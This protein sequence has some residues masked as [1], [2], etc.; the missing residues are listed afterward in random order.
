M[1][2]SNAYLRRH[3][4]LF[5]KSGLGSIDVCGWYSRFNRSHLRC[6]WSRVWLIFKRHVNLFIF[7]HNQSFLLKG[8]ILDRHAQSHSAFYLD[9]FILLRCNL[10]KIVSW[11]FAYGSCVS[12]SLNWF[13]SLWRRGSK[14][15]AHTWCC[16]FPF[17]LSFTLGTFDRFPL[18]E[19]IKHITIF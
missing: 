9:H 4:L 12:D 19:G 7:L 11:S 8:H 15:G 17:N 2:A 16:D 5:T 6:I 1:I 18:F 13:L 14:G 3:Y 10:H